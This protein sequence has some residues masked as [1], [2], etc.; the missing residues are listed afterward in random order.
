MRVLMVAGLL[1]FSVSSLA[2]DYLVKHYTI[3]DGLVNDEVFCFA[4][5]TSG[6]M[7]IGTDNGLSSFD[8]RSF[9][10]YHQEDGL[11]GKSITSLL[12]D[13][14]GQLWAGGYSKGISIREQEGIEVSWRQV[15]KYR[16]GV[17]IVKWQGKFW[18]VAG[19]TINIIDSSESVSTLGLKDYIPPHLVRFFQ[20]PTRVNIEPSTTGKDI[21]L[22]SYM[23]LISID[24]D[25]SSKSLL[26]ENT[27]PRLISEIAHLPDSSSL[28]GGPGIVRRYKNGK[29]IQIYDLG[30]EDTFRV[31]RILPVGE[32]AWIAAEGYGLLCL[33]LRTGKVIRQKEVLGIDAE[34]IHSLFLDQHQNIWVGTRGN[35]IYCLEPSLICQ[36]NIEEALC[37]KSI[38]SLNSLTSGELL[39]L[40]PSG[41]VI[42][43]NDGSFRQAFCDPQANNYGVLSNQETP[44][45]MSTS[46]K[47]LPPE[48][49][50]LRTSAT[51]M[52]GQ[53]E[54]IYTDYRDFHSLQPSRDRIQ[55][56]YRAKFT[57]DSQEV[58]QE[59]TLDLAI[60]GTQIRNV[61][62]DSTGYFWI[63]TQEDS[64][65]MISTHKD[66]FTGR[67]LR[68]STIGHHLSQLKKTIVDAQGTIW[69]CGSGAVWKKEKGNH[70]FEVFR[71]DGPFYD[72]EMQSDG[73]IW[74]ANQDGLIS[75]QGF[76]T[77]CYPVAGYKGL[78]QIDAIHIPPG[79][80]ALWLA[81]REGLFSLSLPELRAHET[82]KILP[83]LISITRNQQSLNSLDHLS[84]KLGEILQVKVSSASFFSDLPPQFRYR[85]NKGKW[86][87]TESR[88]LILPTSQT[89]L[90][91]VEIQ[92]SL[93][94]GNWGPSLHI[95][96]EVEPGFWLNPLTWLGFALLIAIF[97]LAVA[98]F[99][100]AKIKKRDAQER[101]IQK[102]FHQL[103]Q[104][105]FSAMLNPHFIFNTINSIQR[106]LLEEDPMLA[107]RHLSK[108]A[109]LIR[110]NMDLSTRSTISLK[111]EMERL[112]LYLDMEKIRLGEK[113][114]TIIQ[115]NPQ[116][117]LE[118][119]EI[120]S[121]ILQPY[122]ENAIWHGILLTGER[123]TVTVRVGLT[124][125]NQ[126]LIEIEDD[127]IGIDMAKSK[128]RSDDH[129]S[130]GMA[131][132]QS[133]IASF[134]DDT[135][136]VVEQINDEAGLSLGTLVKIVIPLKIQLGLDS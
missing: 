24:P 93:P 102:K 78:G 19:N 29:I 53:D 105:A 80:D 51:L 7:W 94:S 10:N 120:P 22:G 8:G 36:Y 64:L 14:K 133:R 40:S 68:V 35:G 4:Q 110:K 60:K 103:E 43:Y 6:L 92:A 20:T 96:Y 116:I 69:V 130:M 23:G 62:L 5:D 135:S 27:L 127:G 32:K 16:A 73:S 113:I 88:S 97:A 9:S 28:L 61:F 106:E 17:D 82:P 26:D 85:T 71:E 108:F 37:E 74:I 49:R 45:I 66:Q 41:L 119:I 18:E 129:I 124:D 91:K 125:S 107:H 100:I 2:Q 11:A 59:I 126:L 47:K 89:G 81:S 57:E 25:L 114:E 39:I 33:N 87:E 83:V 46:L 109:K 58:I 54:F 77:F 95:E 56:L 76:E 79:K 13:K 12:V 70:S 48:I 98:R 50:V 65:W 128:M 123:G 15:K 44:L 3:H 101:E 30:L 34:I 86:I 21:W 111:E 131:I 117:P 63:G 55:H 112:T 132:T 38:I 90:I 118:E 72:M 104:Q 42:R 75:I 136:V 31:H 99:Q 1:L 67:H 115:V 52:L 84:L 121:M 122:V 134:H